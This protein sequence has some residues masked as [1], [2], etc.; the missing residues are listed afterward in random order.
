M[1]SMGLSPLNLQDTPD[2]K[3]TDEAYERE[4][5]RRPR[6]YDA[7]EAII[8]RFLELI[9]SA[10]AEEKGPLGGDAAIAHCGCHSAVDTGCE[11][12]GG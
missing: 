5:T 10:L 1:A 7:R 9:G 3:T 8:E 2:M 4:L 12:A 11:P 6:Q